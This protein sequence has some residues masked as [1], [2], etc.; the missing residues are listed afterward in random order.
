MKPPG[1]ANL[2]KGEIQSIAAA[3]GGIM[4]IAG[5]GIF[6]LQFYSWLRDGRWEALPLSRFLPGSDLKAWRESSD[7]RGLHKMF[8]LLLDFSS[9]MALVFVGSWIFFKNHRD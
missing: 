3:V 2:I 4:I 7:W 8:L 6:G 5:L 9:A 1:R